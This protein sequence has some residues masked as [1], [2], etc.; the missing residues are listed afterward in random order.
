MQIHS[1]ENRCVAIEVEAPKEEDYRDLV[2]DALRSEV[3]SVLGALDRKEISKEAAQFALDVCEKVTGATNNLKEA[4][5]RLRL[6][7]ANS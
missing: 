2:H 6:Q 1:C 3:Y 4:L 5:E 7:I